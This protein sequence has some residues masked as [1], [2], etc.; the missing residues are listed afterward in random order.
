ML[1]R[2]IFK[3][4]KKFFIGLVLILIL[5]LGIK[6]SYQVLAYQ[7]STDS[8]IRGVEEGIEQQK[9]KIQKLKDKAKSYEEA[10]KE[11]LME[12]NSLEDQISVF[13]N[14]IAKKELD[15]KI[16]EEE[17]EQAKNEIEK[18][19][20]E[21]DIKKNE[22]EK[23]KEKIAD[24]IRL[25][26]KNDQRSYLEVLVINDSFSEFFNYLS[27]TKDIEYRL[28][29]VLDEIIILKEKLE[30]DKDLIEREKQNLEKL[31]KK[32]KKEKETLEE[33]KSAK[34]EILEATRYSEKIFQ[35][36]LERAKQDQ[37]DANSDILQLEKEKRKLLEEQKRNRLNQVLDNSSKLSWPVDPSRGITAYFHD[38]T[39][40]FRYLFEHPG[41]DIRAAQGT[42]IYA[43]ASGYIARVRDNG[44]GYSY[45]M[46][47]HDD[48][49]STVYGHVSKF[50][51]K[52][53]EFVV[54]GQEVARVGGKPGTIGAGRLT[55]GA[56]LHFEVRLNGIPIDPLSGYMP[57]F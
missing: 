56:H 16:T 19:S 22:I 46:I 55:T 49:I 13:N 24:F 10:I 34:A 5:L 31:D 44:Y 52:E 12:I 18:K 4:S 14:K 15:I 26:Y 50:L 28:K 38:P 48:G 33:E 29:D 9:E 36:L 21:I 3:N 32:L 39:Y 27:F 54:R 40:P 20:L 37:I 45:L 25:I 23:Y 11:K 1:V 57:G 41:I 2:N 42:P 47:I 51:V 30:E 53:D 8:G 35:R 7:N 17:I 6:N 43:P